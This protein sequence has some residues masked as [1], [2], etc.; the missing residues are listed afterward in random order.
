MSVE[1]FLALLTLCSIATGLLTEGVK[2]FLDSI[3]VKYMSNIVVLFV[4]IVVGAGVIIIYYA[5]NEAIVTNHQIIFTV[6]MIVLN[7]LGAMLGYDKVIQTVTQIKT[8]MGEMR[9][10]DE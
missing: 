10:E 2:K 4:S 6:L 1:T 8:K 3:N 7:W 9:Q 5:M